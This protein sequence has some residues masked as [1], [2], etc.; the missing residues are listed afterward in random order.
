MRIVITG[1]SG[2]IGSR[3]LG[4]ARSVSGNLATALSSRDGEG[5]RIVY[6]ASSP[7]LGLDSDEF[8]LISQAEILIHAGSFTPRST[9]DADQRAGCLSNVTFTTQLLDLPWQRLRKV[10]FLSSVDVYGEV[11][12]SV[13]ELTSTAPRSLY[14]LS[15]LY[16]ERLVTLF[17]T[18]RQIAAQ[19]L[20][21]GHVYGPGEDV[22]QKVIPQAMRNIVLGR[23]I[24]CWGDGQER[25]NFIFVD[26]VV[27]AILAAV[28]LR[29]EPGAI[30]VVGSRA[31]SIRDVLCKLV[32]VSGTNSRIVHHAAKS[33]T[34]DR[35]FDNAKMRQHLNVQETELSVG[36]RSE[37][38][39]FK[40][41]LAGRQ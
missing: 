15:K 2:F 26:D 23:D 18:E 6:R 24:E 20:R 36:L 30:N 11:A 5:S 16:C 7:G 19:V 38:L 28:E 22:Y 37:Y 31:V 41:L 17:A 39:Y 32:K 40:E 35:V 14:G 21:V 8:A 10:I 9:V 3:L 12:G 34:L 29:T 4:S 1:T 13:S 27:S 25:R 33:G